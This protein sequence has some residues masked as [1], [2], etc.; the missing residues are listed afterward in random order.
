MPK[1]WETAPQTLELDGL[2]W[3]ELHRASDLSGM[4]IRRIRE[5]IERKAIRA[6]GEG[7]FHYVSEPTVARLKTEAGATKRKKPK[8]SY[9]YEWQ[10]TTRA[11]RLGL[12][13]TREVQDVLP[14]S[15]G[16]AGKGW[17]GGKSGD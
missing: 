16:R 17:V 3:V 12:H 11:P 13:A 8:L 4:G 6:R 14:M 5:K 1:P 7:G 10:A 2:T 15:S 9:S